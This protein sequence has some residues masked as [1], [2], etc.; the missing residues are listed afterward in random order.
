MDRKEV[1]GE[2]NRERE[3]QI[4]LWKANPHSTVEF[5]MY[6]EDY[7]NEAKHIESRFIDSAVNTDSLHIMRKIASLAVSC[8]EQHG[9]PS[10]D[11]NDLSKSC[12]LHGVNCKE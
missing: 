8:L 2:I 10:R 11:M 9:C 4:A 12:E 1:F 3:Y 7:I 6:I 5:L